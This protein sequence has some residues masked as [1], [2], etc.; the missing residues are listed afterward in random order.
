VKIFQ[1][2]FAYQ[3]YLTYLGSRL[4]TE[5]SFLTWRDSLV[6]DR[7]CAVHYIDPAGDGDVFLTCN[8]SVAMQR[9]WAREQG[10][11]T[12][13]QT[14]DIVLAQV[15]EHRSEVFY[16]QDPGHYGREF[17]RRLPG[18]VRHRVCWQSPPANP[19]DLAAYDLVVNNFPTSLAEY[20]KQ[21][22]PTAYFSPSF[23]PAM[24]PYAERT[25]RPIDVVFV[26]GYSRHHR[27][28]AVVLEAVAE[29]HGR[30]HVVF[31]LDRSRLT[32]LAESPLGWLLP[33]ERHR[34]PK[35]IR[36]VAAQPMFGRDM[37]ALFGQAKIVLNGA[38]DSA[39][40]DR[41]NMRCFE[42]IG[43]GALMLSDPG[44]YPEGMVE[45][46]TMVTYRSAKDACRVAE[47][48]LEDSMRCSEI[49]K[50]GTEMLRD[51]YSKSAQWRRFVTLIEAL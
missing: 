11:G 4:P 28:R 13:V 12:R 37:Y 48:L 49:A 32:R 26:G 50:R 47:N 25:E 24:A 36:A 21:G 8:A 38:V 20:A 1:N 18:C 31:A 5:S 40:Q 2:I 33:L 16:T 22:V 17:L 19:G 34:R 44:N 9:A 46:E 14:N 15:E 10:M 27:N 30:L 6:E 45:G 39:G 23:D 51:R 41:G 43:C 42:A 35:A 3:S 29:L 7:Y